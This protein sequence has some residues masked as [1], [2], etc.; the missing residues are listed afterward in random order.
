MRLLRAVLV[1]RRPAPQAAGRRGIAPEIVKHPAAA[2]DPG[3]VIRKVKNCPH[4]VAVGLK[5]CIGVTRQRRCRLGGD[6]IESAAPL[7]L[8]EPQPGVIVGSIGGRPRIDHC[9]IR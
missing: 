6:P 4:R 1:H 8:F 7:D 2:G 9:P 3:D 5:A